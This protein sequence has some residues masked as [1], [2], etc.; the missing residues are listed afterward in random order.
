MPSSNGLQDI[1][2]GFQGL[3]T[4]FQTYLPKV[5]PALIND[6]LVR[7]QSLKD[8]SKDKAAPTFS[9]SDPF[10]FVEILTSQSTDPEKM[11]SL[12]Y[13]KTGLLPSISDNGTRYLANMRL[14]LELLRDL[15]DAEEGILKIAGDYTGAVTGR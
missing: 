5:D 4:L 12:I 15:C 2:M 7:E 10:Y 8:G 1:R 6:L 3:R 14:S 13:T 9:R 11:R